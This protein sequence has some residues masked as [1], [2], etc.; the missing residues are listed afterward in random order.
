[1]QRLIWTGGA[2]AIKTDSSASFDWV[3]ERRSHSP[4]LDREIQYAV[5]RDCERQVFPAGN[6]FFL[7]RGGVGMLHQ[8]P[9]GERGADNL[10]ARSQMR[11]RPAFPAGNRCDLYRDKQRGAGGGK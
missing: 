3:I 11:L 10:P 4:S 1:M 5:G 6:V 8:V 7:G 9:R 2:R